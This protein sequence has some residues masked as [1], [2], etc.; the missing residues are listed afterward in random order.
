M[1]N[2]PSVVRLPACFAAIVCEQKARC[3][4]QCCGKKDFTC[5]YNVTLQK[6]LAD[7][8]E[9]KV[10][11]FLQK[12]DSSLAWNEFLCILLC[13]LLIIFIFYK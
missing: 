1:N 8:L 11:S 10:I 9:H 5:D 13:P 6:D 7:G 12:F 4:L 3:T 2:S